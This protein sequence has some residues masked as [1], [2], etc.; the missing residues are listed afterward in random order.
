MNSFDREKQRDKLKISNS[1]PKFL[2]IPSMY[3]LSTLQVNL[4]LWT[5]FIGLHRYNISPKEIDV[6]AALF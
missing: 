1:L 3:Y 6:K 4:I 2:H 5:I